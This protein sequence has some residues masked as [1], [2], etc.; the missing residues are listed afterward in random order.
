MTIHILPNIS[1]S[2]GNQKMKCGQS[3]DYDKR[4]IFP[5]KSWR[6]WGR[7]TRSRPLVFLRTLYEVK[8]S[9]LHLS[10]IFRQSSTWTHYKIKLYKTLDGWFKDMLNFDFLEKGLRLVFPPHF[11]YGFSRKK[12]FSCYILLTDQI[13]LPALYFLRYWVYQICVLNCLTKLWRH[14]FWNKPYL[15]HHRFSTRPKSQNKNF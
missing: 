9:G 6:K 15:L 5:Q 7:E 8:A 14:T 13:S 3:V 11:V 4:N 10:F 2:K 1:R 12:C